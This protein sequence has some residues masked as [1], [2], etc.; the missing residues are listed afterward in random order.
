MEAGLDHTAGGHLLTLGG[1]V[2]GVLRPPSLAAP[3]HSEGGGAR[4]EAVGGRGETA[5]RLPARRRCRWGVLNRGQCA[6]KQKKRG[7]KEGFRWLMPLGRV[8]PANSGDGDR[9]LG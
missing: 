1:S 5:L 8:L 3:G 4:M 7:W 9:A 2:R 6:D